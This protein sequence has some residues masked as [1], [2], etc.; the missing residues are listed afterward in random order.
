MIFPPLKEPSLVMTILHSASL[1]RAAR[2]ADEKPA[3]TTECI[4]PIRAQAR[5]AIAKS[6]IIG[7]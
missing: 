3:K 4:A 7:K 1:I 5:V 2:E 6:G